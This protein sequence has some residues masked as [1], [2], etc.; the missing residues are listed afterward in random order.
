LNRLKSFCIHAAQDT[1]SNHPVNTILFPSE[2]ACDIKEKIGLFFDFTHVQYMLPIPPR[3]LPHASPGS[4]LG[5]F[6][7]EG[8]YG[9]NLC[10]VFFQGHGVIEI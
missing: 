9:W 5:A 1:I 2:T 3:I 8:L 4:P 7:S 6:V 10:G